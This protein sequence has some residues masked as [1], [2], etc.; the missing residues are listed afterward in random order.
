M[1]HDRPPWVLPAEPDNWVAE[2]RD[3]PSHGWRRLLWR[4]SGGRL[5]PGPS[6]A[7]VAA[8]A[9]LDRLTTPLGRPR[10]VAVISTKG[11]VG[12]TT[13]TLG[14]GNALA[15]YRGDRVV[16]IDCNPDAG[17]LA[18]RVAETPVA[19][20]SLDLVEAIEAGRV[21]SYSAVRTFVTTTASRLEVIGSPDDPRRARAV[22]KEEYATI[23][24][25]LRRH[26]QLVV[27]DCGTGV[28]DSATRGVIGQADQLV[29]VTTPAQDSARAVMFLLDYLTEQ[30]HDRLVKEAVVVV[31]H[32]QAR[33][34]ARVDLER[35][36]EGF[37]G[38][39][40]GVVVVP[41]DPELAAGDT[42]PL[43]SLAPSTIDAYLDLAGQIIDTL[44]T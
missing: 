23:L 29:V 4:L 24:G 14:I 41:H 19:S 44:T 8:R 42:A 11:G 1:S 18:Y 7:E 40:G 20:T 37:A 13:T 36:A 38:R 25:E 33:P 10:T 9:Q 34:A 12:K 31:N 22:A 2:R 16:A 28:L 6:G 3:P 43:D 5:I 35:M 15:A 39:V 30:G 21:D 27:A 17:S 32:V 26:Y